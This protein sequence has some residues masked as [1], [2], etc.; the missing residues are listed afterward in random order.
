MRDLS[1]YARRITTV[2]TENLV[3]VFVAVPKSNV[4]EFLGQYE[5][6]TDFV[7]PRSATDIDEDSEYALL[8]IVLFRRVIDTFKATARTKGFIVRE[9]VDGSGDSSGSN[10][11]QGGGGGAQALAKVQ[12]EAEAKRSQLEQYCLNSYG[13][14]FSGWIHVCAVRL[15]VESIL[16]YGLPPRFLAVLMKPNPKQTTK[17]RKLLAT[18]FGSGGGYYDDVGGAAV[19]EDMYPYVCFSINMD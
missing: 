14:A 4:K 9:V 3:T 8:S 19:G 18:S 17:L 2:D 12:A 13:E 1:D 7:V 15:F 10:G 6:L 5:T 16:R 11:A